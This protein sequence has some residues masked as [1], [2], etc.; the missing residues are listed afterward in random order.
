[1]LLP[2][3]PILSAAAV[4]SSLSPSPSRL[5]LLPCTNP[6]ASASTAASAGAFSVDYLVTRCHLCPN[7]AARVAPELSSAITS[8]SNP[9]AVLAFLSTELELSPPLIAVAVAWRATRRYLPAACLARAARS[10]SPLSIWA[11]SWRAA[12]RPR[13]ARGSSSPGSSSGSVAPRRA[14]GQPGPPRRRAE[15]DLVAKFIRPFLVKVPNLAK[16]YEA[17]IA[18]KEAQEPIVYNP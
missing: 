7:V 9:D 1:M 15:E 2:R 6:P 5:R 17:A 18:K 12:A 13:S 11:S 10:G 16:V 8:P 3:H 14:Q 4:P